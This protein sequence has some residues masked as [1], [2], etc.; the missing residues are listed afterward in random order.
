MWAP[1]SYLIHCHQIKYCLGH[2]F[3]KRL[4]ELKLFFFSDFT[5]TMVLDSQRLFLRDLSQQMMSSLQ[6]LQMHEHQRY[7][8]TP[9]LRVF[10]SFG[11]STKEP[12]II[13]L[14]LL[15]IGVGIIC[16]HLLWHMVRHRN[17]HMYICPPY[18]HI[19]YLMI[20]ICSF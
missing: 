7:A 15:C 13:M 4:H 16:A 5:V 6:D 2:A 9:T 17:I 10:G 12:Y 20:V 14:C 1:L 11:L 3:P 8:R 18:V 19:K